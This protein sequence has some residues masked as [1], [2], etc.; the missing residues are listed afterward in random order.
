MSLWVL[1]TPFVYSINMSNISFFIMTQ[2]G[3]L[4]AISFFHVKIN[5]DV[6]VENCDVII[7]SN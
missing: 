6:G 5:H 3:L 1:L 7:K 4:W 2:S